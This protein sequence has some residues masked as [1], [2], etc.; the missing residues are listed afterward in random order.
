ML[1][2]KLKRPIHI[3][4][5]ILAKGP[6]SFEYTPYKI[7]K[8]C[9]KNLYIGVSRRVVTHD[10]LGIATAK[11]V[12]GTIARRPCDVIVITEQLEHNRLTYPEY[13][14]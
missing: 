4:D 1:F 10:S 9:K 3:N 13:Y 14:G 12:D 6:S 2:D 11:W 7:A 8:L 5:T